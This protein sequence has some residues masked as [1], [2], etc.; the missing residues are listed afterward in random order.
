MLKGV[1]A[2]ISPDLLA[3][4]AQMGHGDEL[5]ISDAHFPAYSVNP[6]VVRVDAATSPELLKAI[7]K[8]IELDQ[9]VDKPVMMMAPVPGDNL[10]PELM[11]EVKE[12]LGKDADRIDYIERFAFYDRAREAFAVVVSGESRIYGNIIVKKGVTQP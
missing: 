3:I 7:L 1:P 6:N 2:I 9:Y 4:L 11:A 8:L 12:Y 5:V 10:D